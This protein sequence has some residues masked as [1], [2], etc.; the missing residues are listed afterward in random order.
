MN[1]SLYFIMGVM[2]GVE[3]QKFEDTDVLVIDLGILRIM[4]EK[5]NNNHADHIPVGN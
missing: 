5:D 3:M 4:I 1:I 2:F